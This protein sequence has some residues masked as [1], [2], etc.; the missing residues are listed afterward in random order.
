MADLQS[1]LAVGDVDA[2]RRLLKQGEAQQPTTPDPE[3]PPK[4]AIEPTTTAAQLFADRPIVQLSVEQITLQLKSVRTMGKL[5]WP[6]GES[7]ARIFTR[8]APAS[9]PALLI[10][11]GA[12]S[13]V[14]S[15]VAAACGIFA[16]GVVATDCFEEY[17]QLCR[18]NDSL[19][20]S[21]LS[22]VERLDVT[23]AGALSAVVQQ[24]LPGRPAS[25]VLVLASEMGYDPDAIRGVFAASG[26]LLRA[27]VHEPLVLFARSSNFEH[28]DE[29]QAKVAD[30][31]GFGLVATREMRAMGALD[32]IAVTYITPCVEDTAT[33]FFWARRAEGGAP[34]THPLAEWL[35][36]AAVDATPADG[37]AAA[38][39]TAAAELDLWAP[40]GL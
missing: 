31:A 36:S 5:L 38:D 19:N 24:L 2:V 29:H 13:A 32:A 15:L 4:P 21:R 7:V 22:A 34:A 1:L 17:L 3:P 26:E 28:M 12:G 35:L 9:P 10:E 20:G 37:A 23:E 40:R 6:A 39:G 33:L 16:R 18:H 11:L 25:P 27:G 14:P 8:L 30:D